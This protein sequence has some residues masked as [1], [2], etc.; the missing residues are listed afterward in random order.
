VDFKIA[1]PTNENAVGQSVRAYLEEELCSAALLG[2]DENG[3][4]PQRAQNVAD[5]VRYSG[6]QAHD[7]LAQSRE[8][9]R[10][11][12]L[13][14]RDEEDMDGEISVPNYEQMFTS[15]PL[16][17]T[18]NY[19]TYQTENYIYL[20]GAHGNTS[21]T[22]AT[23]AKASG[24]QLGRVLKSGKEDE[25]QSLLREGMLLYFR[26]TTPT[27]RLTT[28]LKNCNW[29]PRATFRCPQ[30][31]PRSPRPACSSPTSS[32]KSR[33]IPPASSPSP[34]PTSRCSPS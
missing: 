14:E 25:M 15:K 28:F 24:N 20:G 23:F 33:P 3:I 13:E 34:C 5:Q 1:Y 27:S 19:V 2:A 26:K 29:R 21:R 6:M 8:M 17:Q 10:K 12:M 18:D 7:L 31:S 16:C 11:Y 9:Q 22:F 30:P 32:T 4:R